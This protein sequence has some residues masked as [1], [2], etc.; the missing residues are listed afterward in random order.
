MTEQTQPTDA[1][2]EQ[3]YQEETGFSLK[4]SP[5]ALLDFARAV[6]AK[7]GQPSQAAEPVATQWLAEMI[8]SDCGCSTENQRLLDR[9]IDRIQQYDRAS[10]APQPSNAAQGDALSDSVRTP[11]DSL[12]ADAA[13]LIGRL[14]DGSMPYV[15]V[16]EIIRERIDAAKAAI[17]AR[18]A[19]AAPSA[20]AVAGPDDLSGTL[21]R[22]DSKELAA[23]VDRG[24]A[25]SENLAMYVQADCTLR[26]S[27][28]R[29]MLRAHLFSAQPSPQAAPTPAAQ[30]DSQPTGAEH[31]NLLGLLAECRD[32][33]PLPEIDSQLENQWMSAMGDPSE[34]PGYLRA[35]SEL[36]QDRAARAQAD[37]VLEDAIAVLRADLKT[38]AKEIA[39]EYAEDAARWQALP[40]FFEEYQ[41]DAMKLYRDIDA[42]LAAARKQGGTQ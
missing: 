14:R 29:D 4:E 39:D 16:I 33:F 36:M 18:A 8:M 24:M 9:I 35:V 41:I 22:L 37:S 6:L 34:V 12:H 7:W 20:G 2:I 1:E 31:Y 17:R 23:W 42:Y 32:A 19:D 13:Y 26:E 27:Q 21:R 15:R 38:S 28:A 40:A 25:L 30:A 10:A 11:L 5:A 3:L